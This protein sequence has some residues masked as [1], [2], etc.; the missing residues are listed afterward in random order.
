[1]NSLLKRF[2]EPIFVAALLVMPFLVFFARAKK[3]R[4]TASIVDRAVLTLIEPAERFIT[5]AAFGTVDAWKGYVALGHVRDE[6]LELRR[7]R[8]Q[9]LSMQQQAAELRLEN[10]R[11]KRLLDYTDKQLPVR[12]LPARVIAVGSSPHSH[13][14]RIS[15]GA[16]DGITKGEAVISPD[17]VVGVVAQVTS[18]YADVQLI[19]SP[20]SA[21]P[22]VSQRTRGRST[23]RGV[24]DITR[25]KLEYALRTEDLQDG[26]LLVTPGGSAF[27][28]GTPVGKVTNVA[29]KPTG[30]FLD[31][32]VVPAVDFSRLDEV[33]VVVHAPPPAP[34]IPQ[35]VAAGPGTQGSG[36]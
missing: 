9:A 2:R 8:L 21:V 4:D 35:D 30:M 33:L 25:C 19:V 36:R 12:M 34:A 20:L 29:K 5:W 6:N 31:A 23:V 7:E 15:R 14:L 17:G 24:G 13:S 27:P 3:G 18:G 26:D 22:A 10:D 28:P 16:D 32:Q 1:V 11:L